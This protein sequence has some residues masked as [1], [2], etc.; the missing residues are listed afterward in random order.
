M[1][2]RATPGRRKRQPAKTVLKD[3]PAPQAD[4][5]RSAGRPFP[6]VGIGASAGGLEA[7][8]LWRPHLGHLRGRG[9]GEHVHG[10][11]A[12][13]RTEGCVIDGRMCD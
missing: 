4:D 5:S 2:E 13:R 1:K 8:E 12:V 11:P 3:A 6:I 10:G 9:A 7:L